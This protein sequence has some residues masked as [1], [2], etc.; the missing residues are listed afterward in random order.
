MSIRRNYLEKSII[1]ECIENCDEKFTVIRVDYSL[2][3]TTRKIIKYN[4]KEYEAIEY[5]EYDLLRIATSL[6]ELDIESGDGDVEEWI[7]AINYIKRNAESYIV[8]GKQGN[9]EEF[10]KDLD[11]AF[12]V[13]EE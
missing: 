10:A 3:D 5:V 13:F 11:E 7:E 6:M 9:G 1:Y 8:F 4:L 2:I 12:R